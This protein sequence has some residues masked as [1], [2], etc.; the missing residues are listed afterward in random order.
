L[1]LFVN[2]RTLDFEDATRENENSINSRLLYDQRFAKDIIQLNTTYET[3]S[4]TQPQQ[5]FTFVAV[6]EEQGT[7][8]WNDYNDDGIQQLEEFE[9]AQFQDEADFIRLLLPNQIFI[10]THQNRLSAQLTL[11]PQQWNGQKGTKKLLSRF[12]N[13]TNYSIDR[14]ILREGQS[15]SINPFQSGEN[16]LSL[17]LSFRSALSFNRGKQN[18]STTYSYLINQ[19]T[20]LLSTGL[21]SADIESH[22][23]N[24]LHKIKKSW[25]FNFQGITGSNSSNSENFPTRNF[26]L[27]TSSLNPRISYLF[28]K[29]SRVSLF[30][31]YQQKENEL[32]GLES[33]QQNS[34]GM[35]FAV[36][37]VEKLSLTGELNYIDNRF[38]GSA[39]SP[40][41]FQILEG[42][43]PGTNFTW[44]LIA[45]KR[46]TK[47]LDLNVSYFG[48]NSDGSSTIHTGNVQLKAFF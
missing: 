4:G 10:R 44:S 35:A 13:L 31:T 2:Y 23:I 37:D 5:E 30:Y 36:A 24:F 41:A 39:F 12:Y 14:R 19:S 34:F 28:S 43:Q 46:I 42:L 21:Q 26:E 6:D 20:N 3:N 7:H 48:R 27:T 18:Y 16:E 11:N 32:S 1:G 8:T 22:Q 25:V 17:A 45:Q 40:V 15:F 29:Q 38:R 9:I 47:F 33:L